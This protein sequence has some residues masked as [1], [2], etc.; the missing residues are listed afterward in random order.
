MTT[1]VKVGVKC[2]KL[3]NAKSQEKLKDRKNGS[4]P[5]VS[6]EN[7]ALPTP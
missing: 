7:S 4:P 6:G 2:D 3:R 5:R 1:E